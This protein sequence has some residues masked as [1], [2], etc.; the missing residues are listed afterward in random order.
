MSEVVSK[1]TAVVAASACAALAGLALA[2]GYAAYRGLRWL[3]EQAKNEM[4]RLEKE[5]AKPVSYTTTAQAREQFKKQYALFKEEAQKSPVLKNCTDAAARILALKTSPLGL[6][7]E[8]DEWNK[9]LQPETTKKLLSE[10]LG[11]ASRRLTQANASYVSR[12]VTEAAKEAGFTTERSPRLV[13]A[14]KVMVME[15]DLGRALIAEVTS[16]DEGACIQLDL[17]GFGDGSCHGVMD[18]LLNGM[19]KRGVHIDGLRRRSHY[20]REGVLMASGNL[21]DNRLSPTR[22]I[23]PDQER[24]AESR[25]RWQLHYGQRVKIKS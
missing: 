16:T 13:N 11:R 9:V 24:E 6:F 21:S 7:L 20:R 15:D 8:K 19:T 10:M 14:K 22:Q 25:H 17:T 1:G 18:R 23:R 5:L 3:S 2:A 12:S 4:E